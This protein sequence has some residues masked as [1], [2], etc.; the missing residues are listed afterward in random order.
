V[1]SR[2]R[3]VTPFLVCSII[4]CLLPSCSSSDAQ[5][6][7]EQEPVSFPAEFEEDGMKWTKSEASNSDLRMLSQYFGKNSSLAEGPLISG[8]PTMY[9]S[10]KGTKRFYW[11][12]TGAEDSEWIY[13]QFEGR[14]ATVEEGTG[15]PLGASSV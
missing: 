5:S 2:L 8:D 11:G 1:K 3:N 4:C 12:R 6:I 7:S 10:S 14:K 9:A 13:I 15:S